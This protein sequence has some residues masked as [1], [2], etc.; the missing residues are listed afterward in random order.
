M[1]GGT[2]V[3]TQFWSVF[4]TCWLLL[5]A[6]EAA[7]ARTMHVMNSTPAAEAIMRGD[8]AQYVVRFDGP[9]D[10][11]HARLE[12]LRDGQVV[13]TLHPLL[14]S[15]PDVLFASAPSPQSGH[16]VLHWYVKSMADQDD[17]DGMIPFS[18]AR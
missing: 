17:S 2:T 3:R 6:A 7:H 1:Q 18:V 4:S 5:L 10:H 11:V 13:E 8:H 15:A 12:I 14:D 9:V 16:Y